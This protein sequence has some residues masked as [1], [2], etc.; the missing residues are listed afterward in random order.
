MQV[1]IDLGDQTVTF[2]YRDM[3]EDGFQALKS[4]ALVSF[5]PKERQA[6]N[7]DAFPG[8]STGT[9]SPPFWEAAG[10]RG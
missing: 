6:L 7:R 5:G 8:V 9:S 2:S 3:L 4:A 1:P 10:H